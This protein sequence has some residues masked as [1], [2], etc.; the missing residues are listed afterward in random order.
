MILINIG[1]DLRAA[2]NH[3]GK[4]GFTE[5]LFVLPCRKSGPPATDG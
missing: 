3:H 5:E 4:E 1:K 2:I